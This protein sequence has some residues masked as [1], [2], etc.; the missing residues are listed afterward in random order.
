MSPPT[1]S[2][3][4]K[5]RDQLAHFSIGRDLMP[6]ELVPAFAL[7][8]RAA[9][10]VN[11]A[12]GQLRQRYGRAH[13]SGLRRNPRRQTRGHVSA[14][15]VDDGQRHPEFNMNVNEVIANRAAQIAGKPL[16]GKEPV[17]PNDHVNLSQS[18][19]DAF[20]TAM[21][22]AAVLS[23]KTRLVPAVAA[24]RDA[25]ATK[26]GAWRDIVKIGR[27][28]LQDATPADARPGIVGLRPCAER[29]PRADR[30]RAERC[31]PI[32]VGWYR[33]RHRP[34]RLAYIRGGGRRR[35]RPAHRPALLHRAEQIRGAGR[36]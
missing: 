9:A 11:A 31:L 4:R 23:V 6:P 21:H 24:L 22:I 28:H 1:S 30:R 5:R 13:H 32:G 26:A 36:A 14:A 25:I 33:R 34:Q 3:V 16:G 17:H 29:K 20:P 8:K 19:N 27:T 10:T 15:C 18:S 12:E 35:D 2:G 7:I